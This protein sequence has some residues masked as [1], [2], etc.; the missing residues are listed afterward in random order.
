MPRLEGGLYGLKADSSARADDQDCRHS[1][2]LH[3][4]TRLAHRHVRCSQPHR[5]MGE[6]LETRFQRGF[7]VAFVSSAECCWLESRKPEA[8]A[9]LAPKVVS[10]FLGARRSKSRE[11][12][13]SRRPQ[14]VT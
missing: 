12:T 11:G 4:R 8:I 13:P 5:K 10:R 14:A 6:R 7:A 3:G 1:V 2:M 9:R